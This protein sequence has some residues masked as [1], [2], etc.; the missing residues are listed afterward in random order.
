[1]KAPRIIVEFGPTGCKWHSVGW[2]HDKKLMAE[3]KKAINEGDTPSEVIRLLGIVGFTVVHIM[4][5]QD[6][7]GPNSKE[8]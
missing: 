6:G 8:R 5:G 1:M 2:G 7:N 3:A 4:G